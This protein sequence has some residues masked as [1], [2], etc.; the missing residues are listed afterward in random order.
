MTPARLPDSSGCIH[1]SGP[2][3]LQQQIHYMCLEMLEAADVG[4]SKSRQQQQH[5]VTV[6]NCTQAAAMWTQESCQQQ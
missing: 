4:S 6:L 1:A 3:G 2:I 5:G